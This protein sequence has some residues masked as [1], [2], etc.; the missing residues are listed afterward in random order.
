MGYQSKAYDIDQVGAIVCNYLKSIESE[1][2]VEI[3]IY[4][5]DDGKWIVNCDRPF[6]SLGY[7]LEDKIKNEIKT[8]SVVDKDNIV[9]GLVNAGYK[10]KAEYIK[11]SVIDSYWLITFE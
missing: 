7:K 3:L 5:D 1:R 11:K 6:F 4:Q 2:K 8:K 10:V 9:L